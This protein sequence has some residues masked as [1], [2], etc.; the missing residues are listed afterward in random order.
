MCALDGRRQQTAPASQHLRLVPTRRL[1]CCRL[2]TNHALA[3]IVLASKPDIRLAD[4]AARIDVT[5]RAAQR[6]V[7]ELADA[8]Y[9]E[10]SKRGRCN[11]YRVVGEARMSQHGLGEATL[12]NLL[13][14]F[15]RR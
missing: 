13:R 3:L 9:L 8:G 10:V 14:A 4:L 6:I 1:R 12:A 5:E 7:H 2:F 15:A 11:S